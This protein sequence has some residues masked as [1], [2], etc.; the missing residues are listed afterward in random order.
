MTDRTIYSIQ[1]TIDFTPNDIGG[2]PKPVLEAVDEGIA[3]LFE[4]GLSDLDIT[5]EANVVAYRRGHG[6]GT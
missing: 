4:N 3:D 6:D 1:V 5:A 2:D